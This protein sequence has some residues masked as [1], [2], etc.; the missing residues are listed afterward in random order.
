MFR[1]DTDHTVTLQL[2]NPETGA[3][4]PVDVV[5]KKGRHHRGKDPLQD[6][7][8]EHLW[9]AGLAEDDDRPVVVEVTDI[10]A[11]AEAIRGNEPI[12]APITPDPEV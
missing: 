4:E 2:A 10:A 1:T 12:P 8:L 11:A 6:A 3:L 9:S 7:A 5:V